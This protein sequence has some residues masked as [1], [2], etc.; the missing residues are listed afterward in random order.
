MAIK[1]VL[2]L[3]LALAMVFTAVACG[4]NKEEAPAAD[5]PGADAP[6]AEEAEESAEAVETVKIGYI[7]GLSGATVST[8]AVEV[9]GAELAVKAINDRG[10][11]KSLGGAKVEIVWADSQSDVANVPSAFELLAADEEVCAVICSQGSN[12]ALAAQGPA[13]KAGLSLVTSCGSDM[14]FDTGYKYCFE[15]APRASEF[16]ATMLDYMMYLA[17]VGYYNSDAMGVL[18]LD[19]DF[20]RDTATA[21][22]EGAEARGVTVLEV[23]NYPVGS[24]DISSQLLKLQAAGCETLMCTGELAD[25]KLIMSTLD[26]MDWHPRIYGAGGAFNMR[27]FGVDVPQHA[28]GVCFV[29]NYAWNTKVVEE[30]E[31]LSWILD[32]WVEENGY[33]PDVYGLGGVTNTLIAINAIETAGSTDRDA[34]REGFLNSSTAT[35]YMG[36]NIVFNEKGICENSQNAGM[37]FQ[38]MEDGSVQM[39]ACWPAEELSDGTGLIQYEY[40]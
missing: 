38:E 11:I 21:F 35:F 20:G 12:Y 29:G 6:E 15:F 25:G 8:C 34:V 1:K 36:G 3:I 31:M 2:A 30:N 28:K 9:I 23:Q 5:A 26:A 13:E 19:N 10:G 32:T 14:L 17:D 40:E 16:A 24:S 27:Q 37:Q 39:V 33:Y 22:V 18:Y 4:A 7:T